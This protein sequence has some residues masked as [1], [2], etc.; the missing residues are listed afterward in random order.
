MKY[1][2]NENK[3]IFLINQYSQKTVQIQFRT[4]RVEKK[5]MYITN[6]IL[7]RYLKTPACKIN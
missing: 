2:S 7:Q 3:P 1:F 4:I 5:L 6:L